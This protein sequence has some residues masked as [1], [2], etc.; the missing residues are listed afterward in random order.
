MLSSLRDS[1][2]SRLVIA[3]KALIICFGF[4]AI[5]SLISVALHSIGMHISEN[6]EIDYPG[7]RGI[8]YPS[9]IVFSL[10]SGEQNWESANPFKSLEE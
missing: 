1:S 10:C 7:I 9:I 2:N 8:E 6:P 5:K 3:L 4:L